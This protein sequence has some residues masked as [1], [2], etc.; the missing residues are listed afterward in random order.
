[1]NQPIVT[2][3]C[4]LNNTRLEDL[5]LNLEMDIP[6]LAQKVWDFTTPLYKWQWTEREEDGRK[7]KTSLGR[8]QELQLHIVRHKLSPITYHLD[9]MKQVI[10]NTDHAFFRLHTRKYQHDRVEL[11]LI[12]L[13]GPSIR[14]ELNIWIHLHWPKQHDKLDIDADALVDDGT[15]LPIHPPTVGADGV[16]KDDV[17]D[18]YYRGGK[19]Y[20]AAIKD[21]ALW[22]KVAVG[23]V[24]NW[25]SGYTAEYGPRGIKPDSESRFAGMT[26]F[27]ISAK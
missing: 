19:V 7:Y 12:E 25:H 14:K 13:Y 9:V 2:L 21:L 18:W 27:P 17:F 6:K 16:T 8:D 5:V 1:M 3:L 26:A 11:A 4:A 20:I 22:M 24:H 15:W 10:P 23:T